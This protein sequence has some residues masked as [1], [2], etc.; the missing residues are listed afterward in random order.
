MHPTPRP[1][2]PSAP[3]NS[4][5]VGIKSRKHNVFLS[6]P[7]IDGDFSVSG[8]GPITAREHLTIVP[9]RDDGLSILNPS[10]HAFV[11]YGPGGV[12][13]Y[14]SESAV[15]TETIVSFVTNTDDATT[16]A[17]SSIRSSGHT[18][19]SL[20]NELASWD[21]SVIGDNERLDIVPVCY[22]LELRTAW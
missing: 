12:G 18:Y 3:Q 15:R 20:S 9:N 16:S 8:S 10:V 21:A 4:V 5:I 19:M 17:T 7:P 22:G 11:R 6:G 1:P 13:V 2:P 14:S